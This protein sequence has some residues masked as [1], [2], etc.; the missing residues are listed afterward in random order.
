M[1]KF[2]KFIFGAG[3]GRSGLTLLANCQQT[4]YDI[5][6]FCVYSGKLVIMDRGTFRNM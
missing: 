5:Y 1:H 4:C 6:H 2:L 3:S